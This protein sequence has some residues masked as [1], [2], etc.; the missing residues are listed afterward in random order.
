MTIEMKFG[1]AYVVNVA[2][3]EYNPIHRAIAMCL[4]ENSVDL[5]GSYDGGVIQFQLIDALAHFE[6]V[7]EI[8][9]YT[10]EF[11]NKFKTLT[12]LNRERETKT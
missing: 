7:C 10:A 4:R 1:H 5:H 2:F 3:H 12:R 8:P 6:V 9:E 11:P